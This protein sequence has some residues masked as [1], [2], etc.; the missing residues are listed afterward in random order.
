MSELETPSYV[1]PAMDRS[2]PLGNSEDTFARRALHTKVG[3]KPNEPI[4]VILATVSDNGIFID[5]TADTT[6]GTAQNLCSNTIPAGTKRYLVTAS[7]ACRSDG[8]FD[9]YA[10]SDKIGS[11]RTGA[12]CPNVGFV[13]NP[14]RPIAA[15]VVVKIVFTARLG[16]PTSTVDAFIQAIDVSI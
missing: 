13:W 2:M 16:A 12:A 9:V 10:G 1:A 14:V 15:G 7:L 3:N 11:G 4:P 6:P 8:V 5:D